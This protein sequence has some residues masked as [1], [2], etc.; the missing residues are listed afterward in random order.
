MIAVALTVAV[1]GC[2]NAPDA[3]VPGGSSSGS[4]GLQI[5]KF[6]PAD[7]SLNPGQETVIELKL[8]NSHK[9][10]ISIEDT[11]LF[12]TAFIEVKSGPDCSPSEIKPAREDIRPEMLC[13]WRVE[14]PSEEEMEKFDSK[15]VNI[16]LNLEYSSAL[17]TQKPMKVHFLPLEEIGNRKKMSRTYGNGE[18]SMTVKT[19]NPV[20]SKQG[21]AIDFVIKPE[22]SGRVS[23]NYEMKYSPSSVFSDCPSNVEPVIEK[24]ADFSCD[25]SSGEDTVRNLII[26][27]SYKYVQSP[28]L[29]IEVVNR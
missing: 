9:E 24:R 17:S 8:K 14:A 26:S 7:S 13:R 23:S 27:T 20:P 5:V 28:S 10:E 3:Q 19:E 18:V 2:S 25:I 21:G 12:N 4:G 29:S 6:A 15:G 22:G 1:A 11:S 16:R